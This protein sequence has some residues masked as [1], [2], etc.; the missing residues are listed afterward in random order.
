MSDNLTAA[1]ELL[2]EMRSPVDQMG[3]LFAQWHHVVRALAALGD[4]EATARPAIPD[5]IEEV[6]TPRD[7][8][9]L[10]KAVVVDQPISHEEC[11]AAPDGL[12]AK[13]R[14]SRDRVAVRGECPK[15]GQSFSALGLGP[16]SRACKGRPTI[17]VPAA[18]AP[19]SVEDAQNVLD[20]AA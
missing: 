3:V 4:I 18:G 17:E 1:S 6:I 19:W 15:C 14:A 16:H 10:A 7:A 8:A 20:G 13:Q 12:S 11:L 9:K 2:A 5:E